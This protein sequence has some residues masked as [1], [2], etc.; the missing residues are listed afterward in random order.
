[1]QRKCFAVWLAMLA[2]VVSLLPSAAAAQSAPSDVWGARGV[3]G[4]AGLEPEPL[5][6]RSPAAFSEGFDTI[7]LLPGQGWFTQNNSSPPGT[8]GWFQGNPNVFPAHVGA[9]NAYIGANFQNTS[10]VGTISNW[11]LTPVLNLADG[12]TF[13]FWTRTVTN[14]PF[15]DRLELRLSLAGASTNVGTLATDVGDFTALLLSVNPNLT[16]PGYPDVWTQFSV[17]LSG[18]PSGAT[19]RF[20]FRYW[21]TDGGPLG[22]NS[23]YIGI[24]TVAYSGTPL[25]VTLA[26]FTAQAQGASVLV[27]WETV[28]EIGNLGFNLYRNVT[29]DEPGDLLAFVPAQAPGATQGAVYSYLDA[30]VEAGQTYW[31]WLEA[32]DVSGAT[33]LHGP[34]SVQVS[35]PTAVQLAGLTAE[36]RSA[37]QPFWLLALLAATLALAAAGRARIRRA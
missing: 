27:E 17:N 26:S 32:V 5:A 6:Y 3:G 18:I 35:A 11:L 8:N 10:G 15:P 36:S 12:D 22:D 34:V 24:D 2:L 33:T 14:N 23:N 13:S 31:Y 9:T 4:S 7:A 28:S 37:A 19:G 1:M 16:R 20:A 30:A 29:A 25:A 21:V